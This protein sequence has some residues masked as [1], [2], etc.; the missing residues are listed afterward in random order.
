M[1]TP[2]RSPDEA[3]TGVAFTS[4]DSECIQSTVKSLLAA[5]LLLV[6]CSVAQDEPKHEPV[7]I[8]HGPVVEMVTDSSAQIAW[9]T[10]ENSGTVLRYSTDRNNLEQTAAM[11]WGGLTH[12]VLLRNL[13]PS[14][15]YYFKAESNDGQG[16]GTGDLSSLSCFHTVGQGQPE[17]RGA[18]CTLNKAAVK[19]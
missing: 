6:A 12:R 3:T 8:T 17:I 10:N 19:K 13:Q 4:S 16:T 11:P 9:S 18:N 7:K 15:I 5:G 14:T 1:R 2:F